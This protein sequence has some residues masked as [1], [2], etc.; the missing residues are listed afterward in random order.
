VRNT[1]INLQFKILKL[2]LLLWLGSLIPVKLA[3]AETVTVTLL[4]LQRAL[5]EANQEPDSVAREL[6]AKIDRAIS[7]SDLGLVEGELIYRSSDTDITVEGGCNRTVILQMDTAITLNSDTSLAL[8]LDSLYD[9]VVI[10]V[11]VNAD[12]RSVGEARQIIGVRLGQ[13]QNLARDSFVFDATGPASFSMDITLMLNPDW[14][15]ESTLSLFPTVSL[16]GELQQFSVDVSVDDTVLADVLE[17]YIKERVDEIFSSSRLVQELSSLETAANESLKEFFD[18]GRIDIELPESDDEQILALYQFLQPEARFPVTLDMIRANRQLILSSM[19]FGEPSSVQSIFSDA[20]L[21]EATSAFLN[22]IEPAPLYVKSGDQCTIVDSVSASE[23]TYWSDNNCASEIAYRP[24]SLSEYCIVALDKNRLGNAAVLD[25]GAAHW[26]HS[27]GSR[28]DIGALSLDQLTQPLMRRYK[29]KTVETSRGLCELE[30]RVYSGASNFES[31]KPLIALHGGSWQ[32]R[33]SGFLGV[34]ATATHFTNNGFRVFAPFY[35]LVGESDGN[36]ACNNATLSD[37]ESDVYDALDWVINRTDQFN[38][39]ARPTVFGQSAGGHLALSLA[40]NRSDEI[41]RAILFYAPSDF[42]D[43]AQQIRSGAYTNPAGFKILEAV[44]G[45]AINDLDIQS[46]LV[47]ENSF[48]ARIAESPS[49]YPPM[50]ILHGEMDSLLP[51]RQSVRLCN[52]LSGS[53]DYNL[54]PA[55]LVPN[56]NGLASTIV[57]NANGSTLHLVAEGEHALDLC[58]A[59]ELCLSGSP[60]SANQVALS[61]N[62]MLDWSSAPNIS[63]SRRNSSGSSLGSGL[64][65]IHWFLLLMLLGA[66]GIRTRCV[67]A[68]QPEFNHRYCKN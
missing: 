13:C 21:C 44:T 33:A 63:P 23:G 4:E 42:K 14:T 37:I 16:S 7:E 48:P 40:V 61:I 31:Q 36:I 15:D 60:Q 3:I 6:L 2:L 27:P 19:L 64:G 25:I 20:L 11:D 62:S 65:M 47:I 57:C 49:H 30:M 29:Y 46:E 39:N 51:Y 28:F 45:N 1:I 9:P 54:G 35:R 55:S 38:L 32:H 26:T 43:F 8:T 24:T 67:S 50:F 10:S 34:E 66:Y 59:P 12:I 18:D 53:D 41:R 52:A 5:D 17:T 58:I 56:L 68:E 22:P